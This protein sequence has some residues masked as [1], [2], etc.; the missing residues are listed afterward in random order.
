MKTVRIVFAFAAI[1]AAGV[2]VF[3]NSLVLTTFYRSSASYTSVPTMLP[4]A[5]CAQSLTGAVTGR[6]TG[7]NQCTIPAPGDK[8]Y[9]VSK[10]IDND[11]CILVK[12]N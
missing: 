10:I 1:T 2:S 7:S 9:L 3:A 6:D 12:K 5:D 8:V 4:P 11:P